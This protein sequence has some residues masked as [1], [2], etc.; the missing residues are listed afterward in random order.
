MQTEAEFSKKDIVT[1]CDTIKEIKNYTAVLNNQIS[2]PHIIAEYIDINQQ[3]NRE[4]EKSFHLREM[5]RSDD[6]SI[7]VI[8]HFP[9]MKNTYMMN[10]LTLLKVTN[11]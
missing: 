7:C 11:F 2:I 5:K 3:L 8:D 10:C 4:C 6:S 9:I 1:F